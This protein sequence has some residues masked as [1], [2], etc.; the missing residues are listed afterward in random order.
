MIAIGKKYNLH[1][2]LTG[3]GGGGCVL[4]LLPFFDQEDKQQKQKFDEIEEGVKEDVESA[5]MEVCFTSELGAPGFLV[6]ILES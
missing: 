5:G 6:E 2:K 3:A 1:S 4:I